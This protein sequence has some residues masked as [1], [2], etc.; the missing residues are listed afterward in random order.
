MKIQPSNY[1]NMLN[2]Y[3]KSQKTNSNV[4][5]KIIK[6]D[7]IEISEDY[8]I[9]E[10]AVTK[11]KES[12]TDTNIKKLDKIKTQIKEGK[13]NVDS[14]EIAGCILDRLI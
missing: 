11:L 9:F 7:K 3:R 12:E 10:K 6:E 8:S 13:Y 14:S 4:K 2:K 5:D 1:T